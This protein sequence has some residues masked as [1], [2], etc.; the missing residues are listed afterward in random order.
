[1]TGE[2]GVTESTYTWA[3]A[4]AAART[5]GVPLDLGEVRREDHATF[6]SEPALLPMRAV[7]AFLFA[8]T[9]A[10]LC[11]LCRRLTGSRTAGLAAAALYALCPATLLQAGSAGHGAAAA[12]AM[13]AT[14]LLTEAPL[15]RRPERD[16]SRPVPRWGPCSTRARRCSRWG[17]R[18]RRLCARLP[19]ARAPAARLRARARGVRRPAR[20]AA[21]RV[22]LGPRSGGSTA[23][24]WTA[25]GS[26]RASCATPRSAADPRLAAGWA[27]LSAQPPVTASSPWGS[28]PWPCGRWHAARPSPA[29][30]GGLGPAGR[31]GGAL[32]AALPALVPAAVRL[33]WTGIPRRPARR[34]AL[35]AVP[36]PVAW[37]AARAA[38][39]QPSSSRRAARF[40]SCK[41]SAREAAPYVRPR[42]HPRAPGPRRRVRAGRLLAQR[43]RPSRSWCC[44]QSPDGGT[45]QRCGA[46]A[47]TARAAAAGSPWTAVGGAAPSTPASPTPRRLDRLHRRRLHAGAGLAGG[48]GG[49]LRRGRAGRGRPRTGAILARWARGWRSRPPPSRIPSPRTTRAAIDRRPHLPNVA[50]PRRALRSWAGSTSG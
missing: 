38:R 9:L 2:I 29:H 50:V 19:S 21:R 23:C 30:A 49:R 27:A 25:P 10:L 11:E 42:P 37:T 39:W 17:A 48:G 4:A 32:P 41:T 28:R 44:D 12:F 5:A 3:R 15:G 47:T 26:S 13:L 45:A 8:C 7:S 24:G 1:V 14:A 18:P 16:G 31:R 46:G 6:L 40:V 22:G 36:R 43:H 34:R 33:A 35:R 20:G